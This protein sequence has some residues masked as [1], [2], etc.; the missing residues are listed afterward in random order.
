VLRLLPVPPCAYTPE[1]KGVVTA[2]LCLQQCGCAHWTVVPT[3]NAAALL[4]LNHKHVFHLM[5][6]ARDYMFAAQGVESTPQRYEGRF[7]FDACMLV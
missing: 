5:G 4:S 1:R 3:I 2:A 6:P 7:M